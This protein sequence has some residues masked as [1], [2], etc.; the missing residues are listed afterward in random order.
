M[1]LIVRM[2]VTDAVAY[3]SHH[4]DRTRLV[5]FICIEADLMRNIHRKSPG[6]SYRSN[7]DPVQIPVQSSVS[8][9]S[10]IPE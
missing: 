5:A 2:L 8:A 4:P 7:A 1:Y 3:D 9:M 6:H 10:S